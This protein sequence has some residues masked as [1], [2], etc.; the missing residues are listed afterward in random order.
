VSSLYAFQQKS[1][2]QKIGIFAREAEKGVFHP[3]RTIQIC[4]LEKVFYAR[5]RSGQKIFFHPANKDQNRHK[6]IF[7]ANNL[8]ET[9]KFWSLIA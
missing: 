6:Y 2:K 4:G 3:A 8:Q 9:F 7:L 5:S 1:K